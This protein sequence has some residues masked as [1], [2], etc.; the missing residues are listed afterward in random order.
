MTVAST[1]VSATS[2]SPT[3]VGYGPR[4]LHSTGQLHKGD[5]GNGLFIQ[6]IGDP[7]E[8]LP[9]PDVPQN[10]ES[11]ISFGVLIKAQAM[12]DREALLSNN[13]KVLTLD[14]ET[15]LQQNLKYIE[16]LLL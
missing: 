16:E 13:R 9:I 14:L 1:W 15:D 12:G 4:F 6:I 5:A 11:S 8:N 3:A 10:D 2:S 7:K